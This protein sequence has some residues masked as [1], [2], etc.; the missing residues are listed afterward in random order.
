MSLCNGLVAEYYFMAMRTIP[1]K[2]DFTDAL[3]V[4]Y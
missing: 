4:R 2:T 3:K 1:V